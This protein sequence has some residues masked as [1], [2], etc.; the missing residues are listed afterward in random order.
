MPTAPTATQLISFPVSVMMLDYGQSGL[1]NGTIGV[2]Y[3]KKMNV[4]GGTAPYT[5]SQVN[6]YYESLAGRPRAQLEYIHSC[7]NPS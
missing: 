7:G 6:A 2:P 4:L 3:S 5:V 1:P